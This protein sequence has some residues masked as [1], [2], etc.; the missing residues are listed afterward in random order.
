MQ[1]LGLLLILGALIGGGVILSDTIPGYL[2]N[3]D[4]LASA[5]TELTTAT[6]KLEAVGAYAS[7]ADFRRA[8]S[9]AQRANDGVRFAEDSVARRRDET[10]I[11]GGGALTVLVLGVVLFKRG[12]RSAAA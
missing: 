8:M 2:R 9:D 6:Q 1:H 12:R 4:L 11:Y 5:R 3:Q 10:L 7:E